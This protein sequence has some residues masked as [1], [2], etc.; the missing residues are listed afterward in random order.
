MFHSR[1]DANMR[2]KDSVIRGPDSPL[3]V[4]D[5]LSKSTISC[6]R[7]TERGISDEAEMKKLKSFKEDLSAIPLGYVNHDGA[8]YYLQ[9]MPIRRYKQGIN[10]RNVRAC[11]EGRDILGSDS[12]ISL[13][14]GSG[15]YH[16]YNSDYPSFEQALDMIG[17]GGG[18]FTAFC[19]TWAV[20]KDGVNIG[21]MYKGRKVGV[22]EKGDMCSLDASRI[23]LNESLQENICE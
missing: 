2:L 12:K 4:H 14:R 9:R 6:S 18:A 17:K 1:E 3:F 15:F 7:I 23:Y 22:V 8:A 20:L 21:L 5:C 10:S 13:L 11:Y 16:M 19:R